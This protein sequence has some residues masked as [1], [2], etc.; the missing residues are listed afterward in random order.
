MFYIK[1]QVYNC[2]NEFKYRVISVFLCLLGLTLIVPL[3]VLIASS[4]IK[5]NRFPNSFSDIHTDIYKDLSKNT[6]ELF[7]GTFFG[8]YQGSYDIDEKM[9][10]VITTEPDRLSE[11][12][13]SMIA[14]GP[15]ES[16][17]AIMNVYYGKNSKLPS[18]PNVKIFNGSLTE[19]VFLNATLERT[20][21]GIYTE[22]PKYNVYYT[23]PTVRLNILYFDY[24]WIILA[25]FGTIFGV[26]LF[27]GLLIYVST[28]RPSYMS[29]ES[30]HKR[31][32]NGPTSTEY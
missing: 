23:L 31:T 24:L 13:Y 8:F 21:V 32:I 6:L 19:P 5:Q 7:S 2:K 29:Y 26:L 18:L 15:G 9:G 11:E 4:N 16:I 12:C 28:E 1:K 22:C 17:K 3:P 14:L 30:Y 20:H 27:M 25:L 10:Y